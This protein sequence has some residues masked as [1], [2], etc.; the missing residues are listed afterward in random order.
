MPGVVVIRVRQDSANF[1]YREYFVDSKISLRPHKIFFVPVTDAYQES[2][3][4]EIGKIGAELIRLL[5][6]IDGLDFIYLTNESVGISKQRG[7]DWRKIEKEIF[8]D[9]QSVL[10]GN[11]Y[12]IR[13]W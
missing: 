2:V 13:K 7:K 3:A 6:R 8:I 9:I 1:L 4:N 12:V 5:G 10:N 11:S